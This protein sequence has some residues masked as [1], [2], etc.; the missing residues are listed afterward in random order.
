ML[1]CACSPPEPTT[2]SGLPTKDEIHGVP[3]PILNAHSTHTMSVRQ[4]AVKTISIV[5]T[6]HLRWTI[7]P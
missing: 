3:K 7:P 2:V 1:A 4:N 6:A 5:L